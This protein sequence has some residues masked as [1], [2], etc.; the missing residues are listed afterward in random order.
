M[1]LAWRVYPTRFYLIHSRI[2]F[3][4]LKNQIFIFIVS[5][6]KIKDI[7]QEKIQNDHSQHTFFFAFGSKAFAGIA[8]SN[9]P[10]PCPNF[11][12]LVFFLLE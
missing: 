8:F 4:F 3:L 10:P 6:I 9:N 5:E 7:N 12:S 1:N 11:Q 2:P